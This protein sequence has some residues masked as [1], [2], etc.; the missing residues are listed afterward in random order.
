MLKLL[1]TISIVILT[2]SCAS[3]TITQYKLIQIPILETPELKKISD[4]DLKCLDDSIYINLVER[5]KTLREHINKIN[6][7]IKIHNKSQ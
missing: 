4:T 1:A 6:E 2:N 7:L 3:R 5:D